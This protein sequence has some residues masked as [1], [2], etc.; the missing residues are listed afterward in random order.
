V[1][2]VVLALF[3][4][5]AHISTAIADG[6]A[7]TERVS[8]AVLAPFEPTAHI[9]HDS[10]D[11]ISPSARTLSKTAQAAVV[12]VSI[13]TRGFR[14]AIDIKIPEEDLLTASSWRV[15]RNLGQFAALHKE[16]TASIGLF[17][18]GGQ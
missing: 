4:L 7:S 10:I 14:F 1:S 18:P 16:F 2:E 17:G 9:S 12:N 8:E 15:V 5:T 3:D 11:T 6:Q 13:H